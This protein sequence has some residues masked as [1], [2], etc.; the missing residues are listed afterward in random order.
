MLV[1]ARVGENTV[2]LFGAG[3]GVVLQ[4]QCFASY[5]SDVVGSD[6]NL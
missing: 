5:L 3:T 4:C 1:K 6:Q 2:R